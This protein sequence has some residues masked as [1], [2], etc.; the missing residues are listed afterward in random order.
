MLYHLRIGHLLATLSALVACSVPALAQKIELQNGSRV[1]FLGSALVERDAEHGYFETFLTTSAPTKN[2]VF[3][4]LGWSGDTVWAE[5]RAGFDTPADGFRRLQEQIA[6]LAPT[7]IVVLYGANEAFAGE[8]GRP[9]FIEGLNALLDALS[10]TGAQLVLA[11][12][13]LFESLGPPLPSAN[14]QNARLQSYAQAV[15]Q[16]A[17][18]RRLP[19][20]DLTERLVGSESNHLT[21]NGIHLSSYGYWKY[22]QAMSEAFTDA[23]PRWHVELSVKDGLLS[24]TRAT[25][26]DVE[27][28][29]D[30]IRFTAVSPTLPAPLCPAEGDLAA[31]DTWPD[32]ERVLQVAG[33]ADGRYE[34]RIDGQPVASGTAEDWQAGV[35]IADGPE[36]AQLELL[37]EVIREKNDF[38]FHRWRPQNDTYLLGFRKYEQGQNAIEIPQFDPLVAER[39]AAIA[40]LRRPAPHRY[41]LIRTL[42]PSV[43]A[44]PAL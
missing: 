20:I 8:S 4:N 11:T 27:T 31:M 16:V 6:S 14:Q 39:E 13:H 12:P 5:A 7:H 37:R 33:L 19:L 22:A 23:S 34:L 18:A 42:R 10:Q 30:A 35:A 41:E 43:A 24:A 26:S 15:R 2:I 36:F 29:P 44:D 40:R 38:Y 9:R 25:V 21:E 3:R 17:A 28:S 1:L 32:S